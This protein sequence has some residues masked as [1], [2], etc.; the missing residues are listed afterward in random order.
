MKTA[1]LLTNLGSP[2]AASKEAL[3]PY[4]KEFLMDERVIDIPYFFRKFLIEKI[5]LKSRPKKSAK[6]YE[7]ILTNDGKMPLIVHT[8]NIQKKLRKKQERPIYISM[9]YGNPSAEKVLQQ[10]YEENPELESVFVIPLYPH[11]AMSSYETAVVDIKKA[12]EKYS[13]DLSFCPPFYDDAGYI[14]A[15]ADSVRPYVST[16]SMLLFSYHGIPVRHLR[17]ADKTK[18]H[19]TKVENCCSVENEAHNYCYK[20]QTEVTTKLTNNLLGRTEEN[21]AISY[22]SRFGP[23]KWLQPPTAKTIKTLAQNGCKELAVVCP[24]FI[25]DCLETIEEMGME[26][27]EIFLNNGGKKFT[28]IPCLNDNDAFVDF[29]TAK[30]EEKYST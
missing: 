29:L 24:A 19:C 2:D 11:Y 15:L 17:R 16:K 3:K 22:Q 1:V 21:T 28:L 9:R 26:G 18:C 8:E 30:I 27:K 7:A 5:I 13:F 10:I 23:D 25:C 20:H 6:K 14:Q 12:S 4:L